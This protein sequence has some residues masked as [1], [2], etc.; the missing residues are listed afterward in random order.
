MSSSTSLPQADLG[1]VFALAVEAGCFV[2]M[3]SQARVIRGNGFTMRQ[4]RCRD[5]EVVLI[6]SGPGSSRVAQAAHALIDA[7]RPRVVVSAGFAGGLVSGVARQDLVVADSV[8]DGLRG[9]EIAVDSVQMLPWL[10]EVRN[11][12]VGRVLTFDRVVRL[13]EE[14]RSLGSRHGALAVD[15]ESFAV[16]E[17]CRS[18]EAIFLNIRAISDAVDDELPPDIGRLLAQR[19]FAGQLGAAVGSV[20]RRPAALKD[21]FG[22]HQ[23][24]LASSSRLAKFLDLMIERSS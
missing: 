9:T 19:S 7:H 24:A 8:L 21:L 4:G 20:L 12:H 13:A 5:R 11:L 14:K 6:E 10:A 15:M 16:A 3:L 18:R 2:D 1:V 23:N 22:L 17:V